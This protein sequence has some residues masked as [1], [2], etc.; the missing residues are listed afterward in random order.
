MWKISDFL[1]R[2][3]PIQRA[4]EKHQKAQP[5]FAAFLILTLVA[6]VSGLLVLA[7]NTQVP[8][9]TRAP[10][11][12]IPLGSYGKIE[13][14]DGGIVEAIHV[15]DGARVEQGD[16]LLDLRN[17]QLIREAEELIDN[18]EIAQNRYA[19]VTA[20]LAYLEAAEIDQNDALTSLRNSGLSTA[21]TRLELHY[22]G[23]DILRLSIEQKNRTVEMLD[24]AVTLARQR[25]GRQLSLVETKKVLS[26]RGLVTVNEYQNAVSRSDDAAARQ[27]DAEIRLVQAEESL[28]MTRAQLE[29][30]RLVLFEELVREKSD[31]KAEIRR[32]KS[33][34]RIAEERLAR[35]KV[36]TSHTGVIQFTVFPSVGEFIEP[37]QAIFE[38]LPNS[39]NLV[40]E[41]KVPNADH[42]HIQV[43]QQV[44]ISFDNFDTRRYGKATGV[45]SS[46]SPIPLTDEMTGEPYFRAFVTLDEAVLESTNL[47][48][49]IQAGFTNVTEMVTGESTLLAY[50]VRPVE[51]TLSTAFSERE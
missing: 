7:A 50:L 4:A 31:L 42:G 39:Q 21:A 49:P 10:G 30:N 40:I 36:I 9:I 48:V 17:P 18:L 32:L 27:S 8:Q 25:A 12:V 47:S 3:G 2:K 29:E 24:R 23:Q 41:A 35:Q 28:V 38:V 26:E 15:Q 44:A 37:G 1:S 22:G 34:Q 16:V 51:R 20:I 13:S 46:F 43:G 19:N 6:M 45:L 5:R 14:V 11:V 33:A